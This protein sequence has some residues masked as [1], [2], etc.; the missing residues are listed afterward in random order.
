[1]RGRRRGWFAPLALLAVCAGAGCFGNDTSEFVPGLEPL[2]DNTAPLP[3]PVPGEPLPETLGVVSG[4]TDDYAWAHARAYVVAPAAKVWAAVRDPAVM[5]DRRNTDEQTFTYDVE[6][7]YDFSFEIHYVVRDIVTVEWDERWRLGALE[8]TPLA[9]TVGLARYQKVFGTQFISRLEGSVM[10]LAVDD[11]VTEVQLIEHTKAVSTGPD[12]I[13][14]SMADRFD[15]ILA[16]VRGEPP[17]Q[18]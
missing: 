14:R 5:S 1:M 4:E 3:A 15:N 10:I 17:P 11:A 16:F 7:Q 18:Y 8:G 9:P 12:T 2:E 6:P 13:E